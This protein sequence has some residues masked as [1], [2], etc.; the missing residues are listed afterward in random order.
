VAGEQ[1]DPQQHFLDRRH[2]RQSSVISSD[3]SAALTMIRDLEPI[4]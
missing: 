1:Q 2:L 4:L 3:I